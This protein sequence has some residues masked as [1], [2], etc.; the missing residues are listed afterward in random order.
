LPELAPRRHHIERFHEKTKSD[1]HRLWPTPPTIFPSSG[2]SL[3]SLATLH[4][5]NV[6]ALFCAAIRRI[7]IE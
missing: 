4:R 2:L 1:A 6:D 5:Q 3:V 7:Q